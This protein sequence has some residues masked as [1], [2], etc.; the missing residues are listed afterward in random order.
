MAAVG[1]TTDA[2]GTNSLFGKIAS[3]QGDIT[4]FKTDITS[5]VDGVETTLGT[6]ADAAGASTVYGKIKSL[7]QTLSTL[8]SDG[9]KAGKQ[10]LAA[11]DQAAA[12]SKAAEDI[13]KMIAAGGKNAEAYSA[14]QKLAGDLAKLQAANASI[15]SSLTAD[16]I[17]DF[18][19]DTR[20][21]LAQVAM[22][23]GYEN[24]VPSTGEVGQVNLT[25]E[26]E[27]GDLRNDVT[28][29]KALMSQV[30]SLLDKQVN[31]PVVKSWIEGK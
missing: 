14:L 6:T 1:K 23:E 17:T 13:K 31:A 10:L 12:A 18:I 16:S 30:R 9:T 19:R 4:A 2:A 7:E 22:K 27:V 3:A 28:E 20:A 5:Y 25:D 29:L 15:G 11:K 8:G 21:K 24:L 26:G